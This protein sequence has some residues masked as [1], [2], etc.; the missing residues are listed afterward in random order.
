MK[1]VITAIIFLLVG[2][3]AMPANL[4]T[5]R[6]RRKL[7][8]TSKVEPY[9]ALKKTKSKKSLYVVQ[10]HDAS[11]L[12]YDL[13][14]EIDGVLKSWAVPKGIPTTRGIRRLAMPTDDHPMEYGNFEGI[15]P[16]GHYGGGTVM[17]WDTGSFE[18]I[19]EEKGLPVS[20]DESYDRGTIEIFIKG[21]KI[22]G[23]YA[24]I[25]TRGLSNKESWIL[26]KMNPREK[27][28]KK[29][30]GTLRRAQGERVSRNVSALSGRTMSQITKDHDAEWE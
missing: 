26:L 16:E 9:G 3:V 27:A 23:P 28:P 25:R 12:H 2:C 21:K 13:R 29:P 24:L 30:T 18:N 20:L 1:Y 5:Y 19:K 4:K 22:W 11:H 14:L 10:K 17:V 6:S 15:I 7:K 8:K